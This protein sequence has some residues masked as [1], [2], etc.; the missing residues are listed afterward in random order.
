MVEVGLAGA[1]VDPGTAVEVDVEEASAE[2]GEEEGLGKEEEEGR[3][4]K[5][6]LG[7]E[8]QVLKALEVILAQVGQ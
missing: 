3:I 8:I 1:D 2:V 6:L 4:R 5:E 7:T